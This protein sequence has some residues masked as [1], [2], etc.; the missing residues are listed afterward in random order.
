MMLKQKIHSKIRLYSQKLQRF[1][2]RAW[3]P[4]VVGLLAMLDTFFVVIPTDGLLVSSCMITPRRWFILAVNATIGSTLGGTLLAVLVSY[5]G[6]PFILEIYPGIDQ[7]ST[8]LWCVGFIEKFG[9]L[10]VFAVA[11]TPLP[12]QPAVILASIAQSSIFHIFL[13]VLFGRFVKYVVMAYIS[14]HAPRLIS[15]LW[16]VK[17]ELDDAGV[18]LNQHK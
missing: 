18:T 6:L 13:V 9:L 7:S 11:A 15:K 4:P 5:H 14:S 17:G 3:Y 1:T 8:W 2:D 10:L 16:G 12:Q